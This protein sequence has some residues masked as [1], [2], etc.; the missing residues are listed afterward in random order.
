MSTEPEIHGSSG[1]VFHDMGMRD[2]S[3]RL[4]RAESARR[5][6]IVIRDRGMTHAEAAE[7]LGVTQLDGKELSDERRR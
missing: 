4:A 2:A 6:R 3:E 5:N 7:L 1:N